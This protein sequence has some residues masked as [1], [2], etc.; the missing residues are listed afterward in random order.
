M[1]MNHLE[2][3]EQFPRFPSVSSSAGSL[4]LNLEKANENTFCIKVSRVV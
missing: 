4:N 1:E 3:E 2:T